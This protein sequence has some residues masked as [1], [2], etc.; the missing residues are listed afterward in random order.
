MAQISQSLARA[1]P[2]QMALILLRSMAPPHLFYLHPP[3]IC[4]DGVHG[5]AASRI[6][7]ERSRP[8]WIFFPTRARRLS[9]LQSSPPSYRSSPPPPSSVG[10]RG[11]GR[12]QATVPTVEGCLSQAKTPPPAPFST[13]NSNGEP[14]SISRSQRSHNPLDILRLLWN[15]SWSWTGFGSLAAIER[16][17]KCP[18]EAPQ[19]F[20]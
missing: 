1:A 20:R 6:R 2:E 17:R 14:Q 18:M 9:H 11:K 10:E 5:N 8:S 19:P 3:P 16:G 13:V 7:Y 15:H 4:S 12:S